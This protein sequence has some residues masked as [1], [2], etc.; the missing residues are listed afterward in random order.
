MDG[1][2]HEVE[3]SS[4]KRRERLL[5]L[6]S[7]AAT[8]SPAADPP[9]APSGSPLLPDP[10]LS[11]DQAPSGGPRP[12]QRFD[13][14]TNPAAAFSSSH[15][16]G[17]TDPS[18]KRKGPPACYDP[19][20]PHA[21]NYGSNYHPPHQQHMDPSPV[22]SPFPMPS[23]SRPWQ[24]PMQF[25]DPMQ[26]YRGTHPGAS[27]PSGPHYGPRGRGSYPNSPNFGFR[28]PNPGRASNPMNYGPRG[29]PYSSYGQGRG[30]NYYGSAGSRGRGG[31]GGVGFQ[32]H[33]GWQ[34]R[35]YF[36]KSMVDDPWLDLQ[37]V[38]GN[39]LIPR[40]RSWLPGS[41][42]GKN[43]TPA[44][45]QINSTSGLSLSEYLDL[46]FNEVSNKE[47]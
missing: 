46:S 18:H 30:A 16:S 29:S 26:G 36:N 31:R 21:G 15:S 3:E 8:A 43:E 4:S 35:S 11:G 13:Y 27:T 10:D 7:A 25:Q 1:G 2:E 24:N 33:P 14:Y 17:A 45:G 40:A 44:Q 9:P 34:N 22:H 23:G 42:R 28:H 5:A 6:R 47:A 41:L 20:P 39:I 32:N 19:R 38:V 37:P 12:P